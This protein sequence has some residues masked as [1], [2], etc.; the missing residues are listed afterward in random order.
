M[1]TDTIAGSVLV[2]TLSEIVVIKWARLLRVIA[3]SCFGNDRPSSVNSARMVQVE[4][5]IVPSFYAY[6]E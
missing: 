6:L 5:L 4:K 2:L 1:R 3:S